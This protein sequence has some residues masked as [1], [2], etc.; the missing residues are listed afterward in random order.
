MPTAAKQPDIFTTALIDAVGEEYALEALAEFQRGE[1]VKQTMA[2]MRQ[3]RI[4][5]ANAVIEHKATEAL[6]QHIM[7]IDTV[8]Y[9]YWGQRLGYDCWADAG[10]RREYMRD[11]PAVRVQTKFAPRSHGFTKPQLPPPAPAPAPFF[12]P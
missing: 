6:G 10:F 9:H 12:S 7:S 1:H 4:A 5:K 8:A 11:N 3:A 2:A